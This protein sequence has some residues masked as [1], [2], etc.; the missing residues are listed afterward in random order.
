VSVKDR[1]VLTTMVSFELCTNHMSGFM[2]PDKP[3]SFYN[4]YVKPH[5]PALY[6]AFTFGG[7]MRPRVKTSS[8]EQGPDFD[9]VGTCKWLSYVRASESQ[10]YGVLIRF[11]LC[12]VYIDSSHRDTLG[13]E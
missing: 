13:Y 10:A 6:G 11:F 12:R 1:T 5:F 8:Q 9:I 2:G 3:S 7:K 4:Y